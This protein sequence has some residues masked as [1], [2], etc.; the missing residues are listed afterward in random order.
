MD[1]KHFYT[2]EALLIAVRH[3][4]V[5]AVPIQR[6]SAMQ[7]NDQHYRQHQYG[8]GISFNE[9]RQNDKLKS[10]AIENRRWQVR[11]HW[12]QAQSDAKPELPMTPYDKRA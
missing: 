4:S 10:G 5:P 7:L 1:E 12:A 2:F 6:R 11:Y 3:S 9:K 8:T